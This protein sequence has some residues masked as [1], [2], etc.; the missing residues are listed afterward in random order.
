MIDVINDTNAIIELPSVEA[1]TLVTQ[2][3]KNIV[4]W[5]YIPVSISAIMGTRSFLQGVAGDQTKLLA[6]H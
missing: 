4:D 1:L 5:E 2:R 6:Q 3:V